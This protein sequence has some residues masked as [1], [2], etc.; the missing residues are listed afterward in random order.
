MNIIQTP[1][2]AIYIHLPWCL[3]KCPY[4]D[5]NSHV[6]PSNSIMFNDYIDAICLD[7]EKQISLINN[8][9]IISIYLGGGTPSLFT[10]KD[11]AKLLSFCRSHFKF[12]TDIE[13]SMEANPATVL[14]NNLQGYFDAGIN[15]LSMGIQSLNNN[16]LAALKR[17]HN[18]STALKAIE[19]AKKI[20]KNFNLD[21][22][23]SLPGQTTEM[24]LKDL[25][26]VIQLE[27]THISWYQLT[28]EDNTAFGKNPPNNL[29]NEEVIE[30]TVLA[31]FKLLSDNGY[32]HYEVSAFAKNGKTCRH[33]VNYWRFGDYLAA[34][35]GAH[36]K[37][38]INN[39]I[40]RS[41]RIEEPFN[42]LKNVPLDK[43]ICT[44]T[45]IADADLPFEYFLNRLRLFE[46][47]PLAEFSKYTGLPISFVQDKID[48]FK[49]EGL[50][51]TDRDILSITDKGHL[52]VNH[53]LE[54]FL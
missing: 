14:T 38:T 10:T 3:R 52:F 32:R 28:I 24:A 47:A 54:D 23:H 51:K 25:Q 33:N 18:R 37:L 5:F 40:V 34:G 20:F 12:S 43:H 35:A 39:T 9:E 4:C 27:P 6:A 21:L 15:R 36:S 50:I 8:R 49:A 41:S 44:K 16:S 53:M 26:E 7:L 1:P 2:L 29:P 42:Y 45:V 46:E 17:I 19:A 48:K 13:I 30:D 22:M 31:G 11:I